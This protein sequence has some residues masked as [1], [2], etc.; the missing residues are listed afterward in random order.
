M[1]TMV[2]LVLALF[3]A[4][5]PPLLAD[6][7]VPTISPEELVPGQKG[8]GLS[9]FA[10]TEPER[11]EVEILGVVKNARPELSHIMARLSGHGLEHSGIAGGMS[12][13]PVYIDGRLAG[14]V[15]F[16][17]QFG[18][19]PIAGI[20]PIAA[21]RRLSDLA[22]S[23]PDRRPPDRRPMTTPPVGFEDLVRRKLSP[24]L[25]EE[26]SARLRPS[27][28][29]DGQAAVV[30]NATGFGKLSTGLLGNALGSLAPWG[31]TTQGSGG[32]ADQPGLL[33]PAT[34][35]P[36]SAVAAVLVRGDLNLAAHGTVTD[37]H[38][39]EI[40]AF[41]HQLF[42]LGPIRIPM[43]TS[44]VVTV[45]PSRANSFKISN[46]GTTIG[47]FDED[48]SAG[49]RGYLGA[50]A[51]MVPVTVRLRGLAERDFHM[52]VIPEP[53]LLS[54][55]IAISAL[56]A[57]ETASFTVGTQ[58]LDMK[59]RFQ[60]A[61][62]DD[63]V[64]EQS[65]DGGQA[66]VQSVIYLMAFGAYLVGNG[67]EDVEV[68]AVEIDYVQKAE[69]R[70][71]TLV[72]AHAERTQVRPGET[73]RVFL[74][75][76]AYRGERYRR[77]IETVV[78]SAVPDGRYI[79][80]VGDGTSIDGA[81]LLVE[82]RVPQSF[83]QALNYLRGLSSR[84]DLKTLGLLV[85]PGLAIAGE[86]LPR[87]PASVRSIFR[88]EKSGGVPLGLAILSETSERTERPIEGALRVDLEVKR[89]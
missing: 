9:V 78:P 13:S 65:F 54:N 2:R 48:R 73:I 83:A 24:D 89:R 42:G 56:G 26:L 43:A 60:L 66:P 77:T 51:P 32:G 23:A 10:G 59:A 86:P 46:T 29:T 84:S 20:T 80:L 37:R 67:F 57:L 74:E 30:W 72:A 87:L 27:L 64:L 82:Q 41:G 50:E 31:T 15:A 44:E 11:F 61:G 62:Y 14:A 7:P 5:T 34:L 68:E 17:Y 25:L 6:D 40:L 88:G 39:D 81:R 45:Y 55:L 36:G 12:G 69:P 70:A 47:A 79:L 52:E 3:L 8:Y 22:G 76:Q 1:R 85:Q 49:G 35:Q 53:L 33:Q 58:S 18:L 19:D 4:L 63:F 71:A 21:M 28:A 38:N 75:F 16:G